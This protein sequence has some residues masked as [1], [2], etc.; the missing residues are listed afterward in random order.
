MCGRTREDLHVC[1][2]D[3]YPSPDPTLREKPHLLKLLKPSLY[4]DAVFIEKLYSLLDRDLL[5]ICGIDITVI[6]QGE[7]RTPEVMLQGSNI[8]THG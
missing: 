1:T 8:S 3:N 4:Q 2:R 6:Q 7:G 5:V